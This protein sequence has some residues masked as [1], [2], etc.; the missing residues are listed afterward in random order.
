[1]WSPLLG[2]DNP[3]LIKLDF[4]P[5]SVAIPMV[6]LPSKST[7][8]PSFTYML[9][10]DILPVQITKDRIYPGYIQI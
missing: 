2:Y 7:I 3:T 10:M 9:R 8:L 6:F 4:H 5:I 1:M